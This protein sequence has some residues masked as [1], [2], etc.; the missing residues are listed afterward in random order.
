MGGIAIR[1]VQLST[2]TTDA[3]KRAGVTFLRRGRTRE[4]ACEMATSNGYEFLLNLGKSEMRWGGRYSLPHPAYLWNSGENILPLLYPGRTR[5]YWNMFMA[6]KPAT[7]PADVWI[8]APGMKGKGKFRKQIEFPLILPS[9]WDY[10]LHVEGQ[11]YRVISVGPRLVQ[12]FKRYGTPTERE[13]EWVGLNG[14]PAHVKQLV[15]DATALLVGF[16]VVGWDVVDD[17]ENAFILEG[18]SCPGVN[19][20]TATR[21]VAEIQ[22]QIEEVQN[23]NN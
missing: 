1:S 2:E 3:W 14:T 20:P 23:A 6:P 18:N 11:E 19:E 13:Y 16:N 7:F 10:Q 15:R 9:E 12:V 17:G 8:K 21:I 5:H 22:R 4:Q